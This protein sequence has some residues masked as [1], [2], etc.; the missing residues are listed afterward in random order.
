MDGRVGAAWEGGGEE[1]R[2]KE[3]RY[4]RRSTQSTEGGRV[5]GEEGAAGGYKDGRETGVFPCPSSGSQAPPRFG[6]S[7]AERCRGGGGG[8][9]GKRGVVPVS[10]P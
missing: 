5:Q 3:E 8:G 2:R 1:R 6:Q 7:L 9:A 4:Q 10:S